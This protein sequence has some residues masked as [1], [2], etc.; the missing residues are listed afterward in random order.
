MT[1]SIYHR[2]LWHF[3]QRARWNAIL[4]MGAIWVTSII[5][6]ACSLLEATR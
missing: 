4:V 2:V 3:S 5:L 6:A 1:V